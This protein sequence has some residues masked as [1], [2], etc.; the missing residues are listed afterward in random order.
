[1]SG[2]DRI[3][4]LTAEEQLA[5]D[6]FIAAVRTHYGNRLHEIVLFGSRARGDFHE[7][8]DVDL[9]IVLEDGN[10]E[11]WDERFIL[12]NLTSDA[13]MDDGLFIQPMLVASSDWRAR[14]R[15]WIRNA[16]RDGRP[17][18]KCASQGQTP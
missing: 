4:G 5:L 12:S 16:H 18:L 6:R 14:E 13:L 7:E 2:E 8:S 15:P 10:W 11:Y 3:A 9:A 17:V 1:M